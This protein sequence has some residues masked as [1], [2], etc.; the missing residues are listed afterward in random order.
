[1]SFRFSMSAEASVRAAPQEVFALL[2]D[3]RRLGRHMETPS[4]MM[5]GGSMHTRPDERGGREVGS[6]IRVEGSVLGLR[7]SI[8]ER[9]TERDP[10]RRKVW[11]TIE[12]P[13]LVVFGRYRLGFDI[14]PEGAGS[15]VRIFVDYDLPRGLAG[16]LL[17]SVGAR[18]YARW[19]VERMLAEAGAAAPANG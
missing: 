10:P 15:R 16:R 3:P 19:C 17:G 4:A 14:A 6:V 18:A 12:E 13:R 7:L 8:V 11:E 9:I 1:M 2:D 5:L